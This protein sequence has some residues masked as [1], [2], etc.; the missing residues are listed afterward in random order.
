MT[1]KNNIICLAV[2]ELYQNKQAQYPPTTLP[3]LCFFEFTQTLQDEIDNARKLLFEQDIYEVTIKTS[4][5]NWYFNLTNR[6][7]HDIQSLIH[8]DAMF[9]RFSGMLRPYK[10]PHFTTAK[11]S[12]NQLQFNKIPITSIDLEQLTIPLA[13]GII[14]KIQQLSRQHTEKEELYYGIEPIVSNLR[15]LDEKMSMDIHLD[16]ESQLGLLNRQENKIYATMTELEAEMNHLSD[17]LLYQVFGL[18]KGDWLSYMPSNSKTLIQLQF[19]LCRVYGNTLNIIG[20]GITKAGVIGKRE[21]YIN[22]EFSED[23]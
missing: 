4:T 7:H 12:I 11:I 17:Q 19:E 18:K 15:D 6:Y 8:I 2:N 3:T 20:P 22:I 16:S 23:K 21:Q 14:N 13:K 1:T 5:V 10:T 9:I